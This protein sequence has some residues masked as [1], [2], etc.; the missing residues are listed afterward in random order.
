M[1]AA[2][3]KKTGPLIAVLFAGIFVGALDISIIGIP[4]IVASLGVR[5]KK[6]DRS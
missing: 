1:T 6:K 2:A 5:N 4:L 3:G